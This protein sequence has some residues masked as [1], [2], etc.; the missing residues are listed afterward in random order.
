MVLRIKRPE[1]DR[2]AREPAALTG[3]SLTEAVVNALRERLVRQRGKSRRPRCEMD[4]VPYA[5]G[6]PG[7]R[8]WI[9]AV[10]MKSWVTTSMDYP[11]DGD[12]H[13]GTHR[14]PRQ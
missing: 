1:A 8:S 7:I 10:P 5:N 13:V 6:A 3:E 9:N 11:A 12:R 4:S 2:L 14:Y